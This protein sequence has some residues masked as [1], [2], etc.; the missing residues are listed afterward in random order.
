M[1]LRGML[2]YCG[3]SID[4]SK[5]NPSVEK[6]APYLERYFSV[7]VS[8][9]EDIRVLENSNAALIL[10]TGHIVKIKRDLLS[11]LSGSEIKHLL[12]EL[13]GYFSLFIWNKNHK[14]AMIASDKLGLNPLYYT[15]TPDN[16]LIFSTALENFLALPDFP[17]SLDKTA[18]RQFADFNYLL[19]ERTFIKN[20][21]RFRPGT[22]MVWDEKELRK[23]NYWD[24]AEFFSGTMLTEKEFF[25]K[26]PVVMREVIGEWVEGKKRV[27]ILLSGGY[28]SRAI[29]ACLYDLGVQGYAYTWDNPAIEETDIVRRLARAAGFKLRFL[30]FYPQERDTADLIAE[31]GRL[32][33]FA[34]PFFHIGRYNAIKQ[35]ADEV[36]IIFSGQGELIRITPVPNDYISPVT[37]SHIYG[38]GDDH[39]QHFF[40]I[41]TTDKIFDDFPYQH[42]KPVEQLTCF[43]LYNAYRDDY[44]I[45]NYGESQIIPV[46]M[47]YFDG[48]IIELLLKSPFSIARLNSWKRNFLFTLKS[49]KIYYHIVKQ[50]A[51]HLLDIPLDRGYPQKFDRSYLNSI[52]S[53]LGILK[54]AVNPRRNRKETPPWM[55]YVYSLLSENRTLERDFYNREKIKK[56]LKKFPC[57]SPVESYELEK[58]ARFELFYRHFLD[59]IGTR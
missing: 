55:K 8:G 11:S 58:V 54:I 56:S 31:V 51:P 45:L 59:R 7:F 46:A 34:F 24:A 16:A 38:K 28:D 57:W 6:E 30:P 9:R 13:A 15:V 42:F 10:S 27:G 26:F 4:R 22:L 2:I 50:M 47:P 1:E 48:R 29:L 19:G 20:V 49:R 17:I 12:N 32:T 43:L 40:N 25:N 33:D 14:R 44:G 37:L 21:F 3:K 23:E 39:V 18:L 36:D 35:I 5:L 53:N 52:F 41:D